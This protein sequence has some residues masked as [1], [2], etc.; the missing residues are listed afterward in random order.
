M[1]AQDVP[2]V[3]VHQLDEHSEPSHL[4]AYGFDQLST[5][6]Q[7]ATRCKHIIY[8]QHMLPWGD[9]VG[10]YLD[11]RLAVLQR[12]FDAVRRERELPLLTHGDQRFPKL[13]S[14]R[15]GE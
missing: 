9:G 12:I 3:Q 13:Q 14:Q 15:C 11:S 5:C 7:R 4:P 1:A 6:S 10:V 8:Q 2:T